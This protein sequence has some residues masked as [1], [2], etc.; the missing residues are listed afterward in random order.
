VNCEP[1][2]IRIGAFS[3]KRE[4]MS[5]APDSVTIARNLFIN[6]PALNAPA[7]EIITVPTNF[8][9]VGNLV[10]GLQANAGIA[11]LDT[12]PAAAIKAQTKNSANKHAGADW[13]DQGLAE[14]L[15]KA[16]YSYVSANAVGPGWMR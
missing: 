9:L 14:R 12:E 2:L 13:I 16:K 3:P 5:I 1:P 4:G 11:R 7:L 8:V 15:M 10:A 6:Q